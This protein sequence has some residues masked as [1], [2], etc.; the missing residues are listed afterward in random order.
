[1]AARSQF[2]HEGSGVGLDGELLIP[3][4]V[5]LAPEVREEARFVG[6]IRLAQALTKPC[7][8]VRAGLL[9]AVVCSIGKG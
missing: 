8:A 1:M 5:Q 2:L 4:Q 6:E 9:P 3:G 7:E